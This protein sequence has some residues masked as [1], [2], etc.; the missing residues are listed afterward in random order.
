MKFEDFLKI[1]AAAETYYPKAN[2]FPK[3][4]AGL[5]LWFNELEEFDYDTMKQG[6]RDYARTNEFPPCLCH[7]I[8]FAMATEEAEYMSPEEAWGLVYKAICNSSYNS[9]EEFAKLPEEI[10]EA[11][12]SPWNLKEMAS[13]SMDIINKND[14]IN[15]LISYKQII[16]RKQKC[17]RKAK[18][19]KENIAMLTENSTKGHFRQMIEE[20]AARIDMPQMTHN[21][22]LEIKQDY[23]PS[24][25]KG[26]SAS[27][28]T[29]IEAYAQETMGIDYQTAVHISNHR[30]DEQR[31]KVLISEE[32]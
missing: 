12:G 27:A 19:T 20:A 4:D 10:Q 28:K 22:F 26:M 9:H 32:N 3:D 7:F 2:V 8:D 25:N 6:L 18:A 15:F 29:T 13:C 16:Q 21:P 1:I 24:E 17:S 11:V 30:A 14:R 23:V 5:Q 31:I